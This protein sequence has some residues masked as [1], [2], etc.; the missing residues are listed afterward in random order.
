MPNFPANIVDYGGFDS[1]IMLISRGGIYRPIG[2][3][4]ENKSQAILVGC[5]VSR[6][7]GHIGQTI[8]HGRVLLSFQQP[9][10]HTITIH[11]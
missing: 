5:N 4:P 9:A 6:E 8:I 10:F 3:F 7:I 2:D 11:Q 1:S